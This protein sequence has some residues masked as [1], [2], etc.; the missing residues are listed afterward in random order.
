MVTNGADRCD[1]EIEIPVCGIPQRLVE[2]THREVSVASNC[3]RW[4]A[5]EITAEDYQR[6]RLS[7]EFQTQLRLAE[8]YHTRLKQ[9]ER[10]RQNAISAPLQDHEI[11]H[12]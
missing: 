12:V 9:V 2:T 8:K 1:L 3:R 6:Q 4:D 11:A 5:D 10:E 7:L